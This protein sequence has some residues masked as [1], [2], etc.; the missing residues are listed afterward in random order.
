MLDKISIP[1]FLLML[2]ALSIVITL[3]YVLR[4]KGR[5]QLKTIFCVDLICVLVICLGVIFQDIL[6]KNFNWNPWNFEKFIYIGTCFLPVAIYFT[7]LIF[8]KTKITFKKRYLLFFIFPISSLIVLWTNDYHHLFY[9]TY[10]YLYLSDCEVGPYMIIHNIYSYTLL[11]LG[12]IQM[13]KA[14]S[15]NSGFFSKQ[16]LLLILGISIPLVTNI[17]GTFKIIPMTV[18][19]T[20]MSFALTMIC[21][22]FAI[23]KFQFLGI[24][25]IAVQIIANRISDSYMVLNENLVITDFNDTFLRTFNLKGL[26]VRGK[27]F[28]TFIKE[29]KKYKINVKKFDKAIANAQSSKNTITFE[30]HIESLDKYF[31]VEINTLYNKDV[32]LGILLL[33]KDITQHKK[34]MQAI[35]DN[36][37]MLMEKERLASLGQL[38]GGISHNLKTPIMSISGA[39]EGLTDLI[40]EYEA[41]VGDPEVTVE[42]HHAIANDMKEWISKIHSYT[43]YMSDIITAVKG[44]AVALSENQNDVFTVDELLKRVD[45]LMK[46]EIKNASLILDVNLEVPSDTKLKGDVNSLVQVVNNLITN[47]IQAYNGV[48]GEKIEIRVRKDYSNLI[49]S[50]SDHGMGMSNE[51][52]DKLF[53]SMVTTK[54]KNGT[55]LG[56]FMSYS[57]IKGHFNGEM[58]F[59]SE[60]NVGTTFNVILPLPESL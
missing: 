60:L 27:D 1:L 19:M 12:V 40:K 41:S 15:K 2:S 22:A 24:A 28:N 8:A 56:L 32:F 37:D 39:A 7:G 3:I 10:S 38:I 48:K 20:P 25:P 53:K 4:T 47:A 45:I 34:D 50:V 46:H 49:I 55:G 9:K 57:T 6:S 30:E 52:K 16:S 58:T 11:L 43:A 51:V 29:H 26:D 17:L 31:T 36:Q 59:E 44:Q 33:F 13:I 18:Y 5:S 14:T 35:K 54:G 42:D 23:F 21:F